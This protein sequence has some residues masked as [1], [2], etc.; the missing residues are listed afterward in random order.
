MTCK[1]YVCRV[2]PHDGLAT[3]SSFVS[4]VQIYVA[5]VQYPQRWIEKT[6]LAKPLWQSRHSVIKDALSESLARWTAQFVLKMLIP[7][8]TRIGLTDI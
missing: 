6:Y 2:L 3:V 8:P 4:L 1:K 5:I 7:T